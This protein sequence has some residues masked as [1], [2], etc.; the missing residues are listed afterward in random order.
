VRRDSELASCGLATG[1]QQHGPA[2]RHRRISVYEAARTPIE[3][4]ELRALPG[5][6]AALRL[7][8]RSG[9]RE[10]VDLRTRK[11]SEL[12][13][14]GGRYAEMF[15]LQAASNMAS[16]SN[17]AVRERVQPTRARRFERAQGRP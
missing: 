16:S 11:H 6:V 5:L 9:T 13:K 7:V 15:M 4:K 8:W 14:L 10:F 2:S 1:S 12:L 3:K 17:A